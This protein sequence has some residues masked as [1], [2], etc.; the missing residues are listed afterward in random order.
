MSELTTSQDS[1]NAISLPG[2][3]AGA[4]RSGSPSGPITSRSGLAPV[5]VSRFRARDSAKAMP[6]NDTCG[7]LF[8]RSSPS[9]SLQR[10]LENKLRARMDVNGSLEFALTWK[11][12]DMPSGPP[13]C[14]LQASGHRTAGNGFIGWRSPEH[15]QRGGCYADP[16]KVLAR[17]KAGHQVNLED[18]SVL[19]AWPS[20]MAGTKAT[21]NYNEA[22][23]TDASRKTVELVA[24]PTTSARDW[25]DIPG[26][27]EIGTNPDGSERSRL[28]QLPRV[29]ALADLSGWA[30][31][32][33][34]AMNDG[35]GLETW[36]VRQVKNKTKHKNGNGAGMPL[37]IQ[38]QTVRCGQDSKS[39]IA[40]TGKR[41]VLN[42]NHSRWLMGYPVEWVCCGVTAMQSCRKSRRSL[43]KQ[44]EKQ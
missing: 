10:S 25:K 15:N 35:E 44:P 28:D 37:Q 14:A 43:S 21:E 36:D 2:S 38:A 29:A 42:P 23:N 19:A 32:D 11:D 41:G 1:G 12:V 3:A 5:R 20:P 4:M 18:Q 17:M 13:I 16:Q 9:A 8:T 40:G 34:S 26:M 31:P 24:W 22:G 6:T 27:S 39:S 7:P 30:T 33:A